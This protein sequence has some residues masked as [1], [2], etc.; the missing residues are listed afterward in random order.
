MFTH[1]ILTRVTVS[2]PIRDTVDAFVHRQTLVSL[3]FLLLCSPVR[4]KNSFSS[5]PDNSWPGLR[6]YGTGRDCVTGCIKHINGA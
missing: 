5:R 4:Q 3:E 1:L 2:G 6:A